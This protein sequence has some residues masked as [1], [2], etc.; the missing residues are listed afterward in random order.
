[1]V[2]YAPVCGPDVWYGEEQ[3]QQQQ[4]QQWVHTLTAAQ[5]NELEAAVTAVLQ[6]LQLRTH[7]NYITGV[8]M[9]GLLHQH[10]CITHNCAQLH[11]HSLQRRLLTVMMSHP[12]FFL[13]CKGVVIASPGTILDSLSNCSCSVTMAGYCFG[14]LLCS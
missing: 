1:V 9:L 10:A 14:D 6:R 12:A 7:G 11:L 13:H 5:I 2:P 4:Q 3:R 8:S